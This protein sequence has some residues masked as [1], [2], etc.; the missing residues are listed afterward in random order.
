M[1]ESEY[2][3]CPTHAAPDSSVLKRL[4]DNSR[5][6]FGSENIHQF[7]LVVRWVVAALQF[8]LIHK[9]EGAFPELNAYGD[10]GGGK[11]LAVEAA[12]SL[13]GTNWSSHGML[14]KSTV[15]AI[16]EHL[17]CLGSLPNLEKNW[18]QLESFAI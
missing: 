16:Y 17:K 7:L 12:L 1:S 15:S 9:T 10:A 18:L 8:Q 13:V 5:V 2:I 11:T 14:S 3:P 4:I 6:V